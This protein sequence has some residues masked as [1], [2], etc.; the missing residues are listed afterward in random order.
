[1]LLL[2]VC[3]CVLKVKELILIAI[4]AMHCL[5]EGNETTQ[6][7]MLGAAN[8]DPVIK[9]LTQTRYQSVQVHEPS[10]QWNSQLIRAGEKSSRGYFTILCRLTFYPV[11]KIEY[12][13]AT[14]TKHRLKFL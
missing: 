4:E 10:M 12:F 6:A 11:Y 1:M 5:S 9:V 2:V 7:A 14:E 8:F 13:V 3:R